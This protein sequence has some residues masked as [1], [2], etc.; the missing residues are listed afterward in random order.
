MQRA[1]RYLRPRPVSGGEVG[2]WAK[3]KTNFE[4]LAFAAED[5]PAVVAC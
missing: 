5:S 2:A 1:T 3:Q 4:S